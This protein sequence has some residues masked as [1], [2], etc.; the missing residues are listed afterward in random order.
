[1]ARRIRGRATVRAASHRHCAQPQPR[2]PSQLSQ[3]CKPRCRCI[4]ASRRGTHAANADTDSSCCFSRPTVERDRPLCPSFAQRSSK[5][6]RG[7]SPLDQHGVYPRY[8]GGI[9]C[10]SKQRREVSMQLYPSIY[11]LLHNESY[12]VLA[13][14]A[15]TEACVLRRGSGSL[16]D[17][18]ILTSAVVVDEVTVKMKICEHSIHLPAGHRNALFQQ[19]G[20]VSPISQMTIDNEHPEASSC[21]TTSQT[22]PRS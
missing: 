7:Q 20:F 12:D 11:C 2:T 3:R 4:V 16:T 8:R 1:M 15:E 22:A 14:F 10:D 17:P 6:P 5:S 21:S 13:R 9:D 19:A 18:W